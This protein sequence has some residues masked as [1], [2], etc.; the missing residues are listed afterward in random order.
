MITEE[1]PSYHL[2]ALYRR[3]SARPHRILYVGLNLQLMHYLEDELEDCWIVRAPAACVARLFIDKLNY[4]LLLFDEVLLDTTGLA[5]ASFTRGLAHRE[6]TPIII[7]KNADNLNLLSRAITRR[8][9]AP[10][11]VI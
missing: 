7:V 8:L 6:R 5:L 1:E 10:Q 3:L 11:G 4:S 2:R 9:T